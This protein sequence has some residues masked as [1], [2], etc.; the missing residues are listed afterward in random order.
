MQNVAFFAIRVVKQRQA[1]RTVRI[2]F[3]CR[4]LR[5]NALLLPAEINRAVLLLV[6]AATMPDGDFAVRVASTRALLGLDQ[7]FFRRLLGDF[8]LVEHGHKAPRCSVGVKAFQCH[9]ALFSST[10]TGPQSPAN[11]SLFR[12][13]AGSQGSRPG[14]KIVGVLNHLLAGRQL[15]VSL[16]PIAAMPFG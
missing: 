4:H 3:N 9:S 8:A 14:L 2:I 1:R 11:I 15:Y 10:D 13:L 16:L 12:S 6:P 5:G 7:R